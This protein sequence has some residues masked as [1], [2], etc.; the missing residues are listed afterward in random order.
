MIEKFGNLSADEPVRRSRSTI[1][2][3]PVPTAAPIVWDTPYDS[4]EGG[5]RDSQT[6]FFNR[7]NE[8]LYEAYSQLHSMA[9]ARSIHWFPYDRVGVVNADP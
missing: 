3:R 1:P 7:G 4:T 5:V 6:R 9:Q 8:R 2:S